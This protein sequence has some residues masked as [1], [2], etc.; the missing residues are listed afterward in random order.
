MI[1]HDS[2]AG[3][4]QYLNQP[5][6]RDSAL[7]TVLKNLGAIPFV[8]T[9]VP[10][11]MMS[12]GC[13]NPIYGSTTNPFD[14]TRSPGGS[15]GG[16]GALISLRGSPLGIGTDVGGSVR[17]P[18]HFCGIFALKP[19]VARM[20]Q[21]GRRSAVPGL[22]A[23]QG[24]AGPMGADVE[25]L[26]AF[27]RGVWSPDAAN[28]MFEQNPYVVPLPFN[29]E[30]FTSE[31]KLKI[32]YYDF[33]GFLEATPSCRRAVQVAVGALKAAGHTVVPFCPPD[34]AHMYRLYV[35]SIFPDAGECVAA[36]FADDLIDPYHKDFFEYLSMSAETKRMKGK[37]FSKSS[38][39][40]AAPFVGYAQNTS[41]LRLTFERLAVYRE[42][43]VAQWL[44]AKL[45]CVICP[46]LATP[47]LP[48]DVP[49]KMFYGGW[50]YCALYN[51]LD[52]PSGVL[53]VINVD[54]EDER[55]LA[56]Y[57]STDLISRTVKEGAQGS[58]GLPVGV[59]VVGLPYREEICLRVMKELEAA[60]K[61]EK[62]FADE[63]KVKSYS[64]A[65]KATNDD[66]VEP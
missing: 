42:K 55:M 47:A 21:G 58:V 53:P 17:V 35:A 13:S 6:D 29:E 46:V 22:T 61:P 65:V 4:A 45:D 57:K 51:A 20:A 1:G 31:T 38:T 41:E 12:L 62:T 19:T 44:D 43:F 48:V 18:A 66:E 14:S 56:H 40:M 49:P 10:Q 59:Q 5:S 63:L 2:T 34:V 60:L 15:S 52:F 27:C 36:T 16:E 9:N 23:V 11:C 26:L 32:G 7:V 8:L 28:S 50:S 39:R 54:S 25:S 30:I 64:D 24:T 33:D 37:F 3:F